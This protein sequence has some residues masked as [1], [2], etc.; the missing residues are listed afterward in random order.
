MAKGRVVLDLLQQ[1]NI[2]SQT[3]YEEP[4]KNPLKLAICYQ[5]ACEMLNLGKIHGVGEGYF[6]RNFSIYAIPTKDCTIILGLN[7]GRGVRYRTC[8]PDRISEQNIISPKE[9]TQRLGL[10]VCATYEALLE[11]IREEMSMEKYKPLA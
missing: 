7:L 6:Q 5:D 3:G 10:A 4:P 11:E 9:Y 2:L 1:E 8:V